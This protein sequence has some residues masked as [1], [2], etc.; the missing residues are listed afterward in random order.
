MCRFCRERCESLFGVIS[1][2]TTA[3]P[4]AVVGW[5]GF[6]VAEG[7]GVVGISA[8]SGSREHAVGGLELR[9]NLK[10]GDVQRRS[11]TGG[12][13]VRCRAARSRRSKRE[14]ISSQGSRGMAA[15]AENTFHAVFL[16]RT[17]ATTPM[18]SFVMELDSASALREGGPAPLARTLER[19][20]HHTS[21]GDSVAQVPITAMLD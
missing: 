6:G 5:R 8:G 2:G 1:D 4:D 21:G 10:S 16:R 7:A 18:R 20:R 15:T 9:R 12:C 13:S 11:A 19:Y 3:A 14:T 17:S